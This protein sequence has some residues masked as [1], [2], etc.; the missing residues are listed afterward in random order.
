MATVDI[1]LQAVHGEAIKSLLAADGGNE[2]AA[3]ML[4]GSAE[5]SCDPWSNMPRRRLMSHVVVPIK[6][7]ELVDASPA[8]ITWGTDS[9]M[10]LFGRASDEG[11][12][13]GIVHTHPN[14]PAAF[15]AQDDKNE[16][17]LARTAFLK[18]C[19]GFI[20]IVITGDEQILARVWTSANTY[21]SID[22]IFHVGARVSLSNTDKSQSN[23]D[24]LDRQARLFGDAA[25][26]LIAS[27]RIGIAGGGA[28][29]SAV[30]ALLMRLGVCDALLLEKDIVEHSNLNRLH[31]ARR[32]DAE[33]RARKSDVHSR[34]VAETNLGMRLVTI[35][36]FV[37][38]PG[39]VEALKACDIVFSC[40]DDHAG[41]LVLNRFSRFYSIP[42]IDVGLAM[43][44]RETGSFD[45]FARTS[46]L[47]DGHPCLICGGHIDPRRASEEALKRRDPDSYALLKEEA[48]VLGEGDPSPAVVTFTTEAACMAVNELL[49]A[50]TGFHGHDGM[51]PTRIRRFHACDDRFP[52]I[53]RM[54][55]CPACETPETLGRGDIEP[56]LNMVL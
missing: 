36:A 38:D 19:R 40:T 35:D 6:E 53:E 5:I 7:H 33:N 39:S 34:T 51:R 45:L 48:Y 42:V 22:R 18:G 26:E 17:E 55:G 3:T 10:R 12:V 4:F 8:H 29:G 49:A 41:R 30:L 2:A 1:I 44:K 13:P 15:S 24:Y 28:T 56:L 20:S 37:G 43:Q 52:L 27:L 46:T 25:N 21:E 9:L 32:I 50:I 31:G 54:H 47:V 16:A 14:G 11:F 23:I